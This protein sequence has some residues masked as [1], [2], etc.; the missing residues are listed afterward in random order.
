MLKTELFA[1]TTDNDENARDKAQT[2]TQTYKE[3]NSQQSSNLR[4]IL[5]VTN[6]P[7]FDDQSDSDLYGLSD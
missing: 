3:L 7:A 1:Y 2:I 6:I 4:K 5:D